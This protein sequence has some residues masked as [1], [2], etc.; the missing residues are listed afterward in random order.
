MSSSLKYQKLNQN[1][2]K[3]TTNEKDKSLSEYILATKYL[4]DPNEQNM[5]ANAQCYH[6]CQAQSR[7]GFLHEAPKSSNSSS[8][9]G[10]VGVEISSRTR[11]QPERMP[12]TSDYTPSTPLASL[13]SVSVHQQL[14]SG[15]SLTDGESDTDQLASSGSCVIVRAYMRLCSFPVQLHKFILLLRYTKQKQNSKQTQASITR[16]IPGNRA[17]KALLR[18]TSL[19][20]L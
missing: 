13:S 17:P 4:Q 5:C 20:V 11:N 7:V 2:P 19:N 8:C 16:L 14:W 1:I 3:Q 18:C 9:V 15:I 12:F 6:N 10:A